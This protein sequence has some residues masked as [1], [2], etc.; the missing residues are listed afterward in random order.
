MKQETATCLKLD[1]LQKVWNTRNM[2]KQELQILTTLVEKLQEQV[3]AR[4]DNDV[5]NE[6]CDCI[7]FYA[8]LEFDK[9]N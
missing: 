3:I 5:L 8:V 2:T 9:T 1:I 7:K 6:A 4:G